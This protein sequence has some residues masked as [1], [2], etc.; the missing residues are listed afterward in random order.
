L[1]EEFLRRRDAFRKEHLHSLDSELQERKNRNDDVEGFFANEIL[2]IRRSARIIAWATVVTA[3][4]TA[5]AAVAAWMA[6][7]F[8]YG[9]TQ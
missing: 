2:T 6:I 3:I 8:Q 7:Y 5:A 9:H 4:A 1:N